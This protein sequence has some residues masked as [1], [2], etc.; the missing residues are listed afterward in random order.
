MPVHRDLDLLPLDC[1]A[2]WREACCHAAEA[3]PC[4]PEDQ[5]KRNQ[6]RGGALS[7]AFWTLK[8]ATPQSE[9]ELRKRDR[10]LATLASLIALLL[11]P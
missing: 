2:I 6:A 10:L 8:L 9:S 7:H 11:L 1:G 5:V 3:A 4:G